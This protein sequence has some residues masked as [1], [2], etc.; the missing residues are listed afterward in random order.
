MATGRCRNLLGQGPDKCTSDDDCRCLA[1]QIRLRA[2]GATTAATECAPV[3]GVAQPLTR[4]TRDTVPQARTEGNTNALACHV[5]GSGGYPAYGVCQLSAEPYGAGHSDPCLNDGEC[6]DGSC[7]LGVCRSPPGVAGA[8]SL[9]TCHLASNGLTADQRQQLLQGKVTSVQ[10]ASRDGKTTARV[11]RADLC[12][13]GIL[14]DATTCD[15]GALQ[16]VRAARGVA[17]R[18]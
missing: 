11:G 1:G 6:A 16:E 5:A 10:V 12:D 13:A 18:R 8:G 15:L 14:R 17:P 4:P 2:G 7:H 3:A 9:K